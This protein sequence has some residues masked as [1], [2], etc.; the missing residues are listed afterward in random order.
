M[1]FLYRFFCGVLTVEFFG[2]YPEKL[3][4]LCAKNGISIWS[5]RYIKQRI[6]CNITVKD[7][8]KL[9]KILRKSGIRVHITEKKGFPFF[10]KKYHKRLGL[11][12]GLALFLGFLQIMS[13]FVWVVDIV[14]NERVSNSE[15]ISACE[16]LGVKAGVRK[17]KINA[18]ADAQELL[19]K[20]DKLA[21]GSLNIEGCKLTVN[22]TEVI[23]KKEDNSV[24]SNLKASEDG[25]IKHIDVTSGNCLVKV[26][27]IVSKGDILVSGI[28][29]NESGTRFVHS[30]GTIIAETETAVSLKEKYLKQVKIPTGKV[31]TKYAVDFFTLK[32]PLYVGS[33]KGEYSTQSKVKV[34]ELFSQKLPI[35]IYSKKFIF[36]RNESIETDYNKAVEVLEKRLAEEYKGKVKTKDFTD[37]GEGVVL[38]AVLVDQKNIAVSENLIFSIGK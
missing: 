21:W 25:V 34:L 29:E 31:K 10:I 9:P 3:L 20:I 1:L 13:G 22:V 27:D 35:K 36:S 28:I 7:F 23:E 4:N 14:G 24:A 12:I 37:S 26:G 30:I 2:I 38:N 8:L 32:I 18:K 6:R 5:A 17:S 15:I 33:E 11:F 16:E 19:L